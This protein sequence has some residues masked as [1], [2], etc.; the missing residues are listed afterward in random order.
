MGFRILFLCLIGA[1]A[2]RANVAIL[3]RDT[4]YDVIARYTDLMVDAG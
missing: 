3:H 2:I 1:V 4:D